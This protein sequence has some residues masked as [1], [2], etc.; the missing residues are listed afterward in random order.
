[1]LSDVYAIAPDGTLIKLTDRAAGFYLLS[2]TGLSMR[3]V[4]PVVGRVPYLDGARLRGSYVAERKV[5]VALGIV[6]STPGALQ[7][8][9]AALQS[10]LSPKRIVDPTSEHFTL[11]VVTLD[12]RTRD[13]DGLFTLAD[14]QYDGPCYARVSLTF[15]APNPF[16]YDPEEHEESLSL[17]AGTG[18]GFPLSFSVS[19]ASTTI[20]GHIYPVNGG[21][22]E[23]WPVIRVTGPADNPALTNVTTGKK[24]EITQAQ[25]TD[26]YIEIDM[27]NGTVMFYDASLGTLTSILKNISADSE[28]WSLAVGENDIHVVAE[29]ASGG[30]ITLSWYDRFVGV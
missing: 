10:Q 5:A 3:D 1:M 16:W 2:V 6:K 30:S 21:D 13:V 4:N 22:V 15:H 27:E 24:V 28:F 11:R 8:A 9:V 26:D 23:V 17:P 19:F 18:A 25:D 29:N 20:D 7:E 12:G 14:V